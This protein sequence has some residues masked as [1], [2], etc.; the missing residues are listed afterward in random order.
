[1]YPFVRCGTLMMLETL[2]EDLGRARVLELLRDE[3]AAGD[4]SSVDG[5]GRGLDVVGV[6]FGQVAHVLL[7]LV[8]LRPV[9]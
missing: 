6:A 9:L 5:D 1:M 7:Q 8:G 4:G 3:V 2:P